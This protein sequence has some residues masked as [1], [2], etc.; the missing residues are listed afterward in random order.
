MKWFARAGILVLGIVLSW[1]IWQRF[2]VSDE[3]RIHRAITSMERAVET[4][5]LFRLEDGIAQEYADGFGFDK[6]TLLGVVRAFRSQH[7][8]VFI[9]LSEMTITV[10]DGE[11]Q[12][13]FIAKIL[14]RKK[15]ALAETELR[16]DRFRLFF[17]K[18]EQGW[19][20]TGAESP[21]LKFD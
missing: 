11:G 13:A 21:E 18:T 20:L 3:Q 6:S 14:V 17:R 1:W 7:D 12:A 5:N 16:S 19:K 9:H 2:F 10:Q 8:G 4:G 15:G